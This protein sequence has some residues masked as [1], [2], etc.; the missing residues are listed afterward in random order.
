MPYWALAKG[1][2][3]GKYR[4]GGDE[5]DSVRAG[6]ATAYLDERGSGILAALDD[7]AAAHDTTV[8]SV[9]IA[10]LAA[11][12]TVAS[13]IASARNVEQLE[14]ILPAQTLDLTSAELEAIDAAS[15]PA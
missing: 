5:V 12:P 11:Q 3:T 4:E 15:A 9:A 6:A 13:P 2:L 7:V 10:W 1:F 14:Q 8:A